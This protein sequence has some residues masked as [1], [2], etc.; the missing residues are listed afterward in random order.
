MSLSDIVSKVVAET[1]DASGSIV[2]RDAVEIGK[3]LVREDEEA[4]DQCISEALAIRIKAAA[5]RENKKSEKRDPRQPELFGLRPRHA[6]DIEGR[7]LKSTHALT[8]I[9]FERIR[10]IRRE[11]LVADA[12][13]LKKL[14]DAA[15]ALSTIWDSNPEL[16]FGEVC[17]LFQKAA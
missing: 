6:L 2:T 7:I 13:Y 17:D 8:R 3:P 16:T 9:E 10:Q 14:D 12:A 1:Q 5:Q 11:S 15:R 4:V